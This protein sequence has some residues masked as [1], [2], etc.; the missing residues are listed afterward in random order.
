MANRT[1]KQILEEIKEI[2]EQIVSGVEDLSRL[3]KIKSL[4]SI[5]YDQKLA[6]ET[7]KE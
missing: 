7:N 5:E 2:D 1:L 3:I 6:E 4:L